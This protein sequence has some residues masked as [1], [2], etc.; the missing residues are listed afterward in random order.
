MKRG[1]ECGA[2]RQQK[3]Q[4]QRASVLDSRPASDAKKRDRC[5]DVRKNLKEAKDVDKGDAQC[6]GEHVDHP[7]V[8][9]GKGRMVHHGGVRVRTGDAHALDEIDRDGHEA[10]VVRAIRRRDQDDADRDG[11]QREE[12]ECAPLEKPRHARAV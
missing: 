7:H 8:R 10:G 9:E 4:R 5:D 12:P 3:K 6:A 2:R 11:E 1:D